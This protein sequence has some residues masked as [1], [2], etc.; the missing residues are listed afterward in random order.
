M[1]QQNTLILTLP[2]DFHHVKHE[3]YG[4]NVT[5]DKNRSQKVK[6]SQLKYK[7]GAILQKKYYR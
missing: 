3:N 1:H 5:P 7:S 6:T 2:L 4:I